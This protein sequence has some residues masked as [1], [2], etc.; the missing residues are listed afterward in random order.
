MP[1]GSPTSFAGCASLTHSQN[2]GY[3]HCCQRGKKG[4]LE[5][6]QSLQ[7][8]ANSGT[9]EGRSGQRTPGPLMPAATPAFPASSQ[10]LAA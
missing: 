4:R 3:P 5:P 6:V 9:T 7:H 1:T 8:A 2:S 10:D